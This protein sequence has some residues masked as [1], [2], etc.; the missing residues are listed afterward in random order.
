VLSLIQIARVL[1]GG[2]IFATGLVGFI[3]P[4]IPGI[5]LLILGAS[6]GLTWH[7]KGLRI[8]RR[9]KSKTLRVF[10]KKKPAA[11]KA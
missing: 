1:I 7:P 11:L 2:A 5:P 8:W 4:F 10:F 6:I 9:L 3:L